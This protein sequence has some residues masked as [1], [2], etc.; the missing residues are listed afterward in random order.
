ML[1][2]TN[3]LV[4]V[5]AF[6]PLI[7]AILYAGK[8][9]TVKVKRTP[10]VYSDGVANNHSC[11]CTCVFSLILAILYAGKGRT[12]TPAS[13]RTSMG[14]Q[15]LVLVVQAARMPP[16]CGSLGVGGGTAVPPCT[17]T[18]A[19]SSWDPPQEIPRVHSRRQCRI[20]DKPTPSRQLLPSPQSHGCLGRT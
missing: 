18:V 5:L 15:L 8:G 16:P 9:R 1:P 3:T 20:V 11:T 10:W 19:G 14:S 4:H 17:S 12:E 2:P 6:F 7:L 13:K